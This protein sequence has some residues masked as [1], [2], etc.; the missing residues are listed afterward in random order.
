[1][2][3]FIVGAKGSGKTKTLADMVNT[4]ATETM[5]NIVCI[6]KSMKLT[7]DIRHTVRLIDVDEYNISGYEQF[8]GFIAGVLAGNYDITEIYIDGILRIGAHDLGGFEK[9]IEQLSVLCN[10]VKVVLTVSEKPER[11]PVSLRQYQIN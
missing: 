1:L 3:E 5:G 4:A 11:L 6:E 9:F 7:Y 8:Y 2:I 10:N